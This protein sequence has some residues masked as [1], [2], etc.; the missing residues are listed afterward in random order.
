[1]GY[2]VR[3]LGTTNPDLSVQEVKNALASAALKSTVTL[4]DGTETAWAALEIGD[5][6]G[7]VFAVIERNMV[8]DGELGQEELDEFIESLEGAKPESAA[9]WLKGF[10]PRVKV[11][12]AFQLL[13][14][15]MDDKNYP[16]VATIREFIWNKVGGI[17][18]ADGEGFSNEDA[19]H[20]LWEFSDTVTGEW[21]MAVLG[22]SGQWTRFAMDLGNREHRAAFLAGK[23]PSGV[24]PLK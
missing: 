9:K 15:A 24:T 17:L 4:V 6:K 14:A 18:Q 12:Y 23:I 5:A 11:I 3:V 19:Y 16:T 21:H 22:G 13:S 10:F 1:M 7:D 8:V 2:Y 20:I